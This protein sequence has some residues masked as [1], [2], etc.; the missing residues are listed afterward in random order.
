MFTEIP[1]FVFPA[2]LLARLKKE[3]PAEPVCDE[4]LR[5]LLQNVQA[6][7]ALCRRNLEFTNDPTLIDMYI[8]AIKSLEK[9]YAHLMQLA[10]NE[11]S[12]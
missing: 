8:Y 9:R 12:A 6:D 10:K 3:K 1:K 11:H 2:A 4:M 7:I 5:R